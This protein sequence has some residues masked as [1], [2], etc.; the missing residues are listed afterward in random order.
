MREMELAGP[1]AIAP[2]SGGSANVFRI[3]LDDRSAVVLKSFA[4]DHVAPHRDAYAASLLA[5]LAL[6]TTRYLLIDE[7]KTR[8]PFRF[9]L[10]TYLNGEPAETFAAHA[11]YPDLFRQIGALA[12][13]LHSVKLPAFGE[14][15]KPT[16]PDNASHIRGFADY[17]FGR[18]VAYGGGSKLAVTLRA[19]FDRDFDRLAGAS[20][21]PVFAHDDLHPGNIL[22]T[23]ANGQLAISGLID[24]GN[25]QASASVTDLAK[26]IFICEHSAPGCAPAILEGYGSIDHPSPREAL[27]M[28]TLL[29]RVT[30]WWW[31]RH[32]GALPS[33]DTPNDIIPALELTAAEG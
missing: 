4:A 27:A 28:Y 14:L 31:L 12:K 2:L 16:N 18:F 3:D 32:I 9:A 33:A 23:E 26:T 29:H 19:I 13:T 21:Q 17:S 6:P 20:T 15:P 30:M 11:A 22:V 5:D 1:V 8:L 24:F 7:S 10:T 25:A